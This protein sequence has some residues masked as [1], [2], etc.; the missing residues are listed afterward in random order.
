MI[1]RKMTL[2]DYDSVYQ[3]WINTPGMGL[4]DVDDSRV[5]IEKYLRRNPDTC[6]IAE[7]DGRP[8][9]AV[10]SGHDG[11]RALI[12]H[13]AVIGNFQ[14]RGIG[15]KLLDEVLRALREEGI[16]KVA[17]VVLSNNEKGNA[18]WE[19]QGFPNRKDLIYR[20]RQ[21]GEF[22]GFHTQ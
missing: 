15:G 13:L 6:F 20:N 5:G 10:L 19:K 7:E 4:N 3:I 2:D 12:Y 14:R 17:L 18:F 9:G 1:I 11:R 22:K 8:I 21:I 16:Q